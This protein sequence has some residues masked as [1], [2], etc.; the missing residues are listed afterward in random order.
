MRWKI[1]GVSEPPAHR[2][3][4]SRY[5]M[6]YGWMMRFTG[7][8]PVNP[9]NAQAFVNGTSTDPVAP[10]TTTTVD[11][12]LLLRVGGFDT[13]DI[14]VDEPGLAGH[15]PITMDLGGSGL[16]AVSGGAGYTIQAT[17]GITDTSTF[18]LTAREQ[19]VTGTIA[20][21]PDPN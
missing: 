12:A 17:A 16:G 3:T 15:T 5:E 21:A 19:Y 13:E 6:K 10:A 4:S 8:D 1:A 20:I 7:H 18:T 14:V 2:F 9:I 11:N